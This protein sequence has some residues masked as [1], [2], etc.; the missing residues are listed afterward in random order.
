MTIPRA[1]HADFYL[2][3]EGAGI[4]VFTQK[5][6]KGPS[7]PSPPFAPGNQIILYANVTYYE[8]PEQNKEVAFHIFDPRQDFFILSASTNTSGIAA[9][10][11]RLPSPEGAENISGTWRAISSVEIAEVHVVDTLE[12]YVVWNVADVN[13]DLKVDIYDAVTCA[14]AYGSKPSDLHW[15]PHCDIAEPYRIIDIFDIVTIAGSYGKE[16]NL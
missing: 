5:G 8:W 14:A 6:G 15:N 4:D 3:L 16:Y 9:V 2:I 7:V 11:F 12:F 10:S 13:Q 1:R